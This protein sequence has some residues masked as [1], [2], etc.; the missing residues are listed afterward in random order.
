MSI[1]SIQCKDQQFFGIG[2]KKQDF[3]TNK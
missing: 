3:T 1:L 2:T